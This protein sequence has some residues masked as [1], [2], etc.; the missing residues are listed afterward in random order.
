MTLGAVA[1]A[2]NPMVPKKVVPH[3][4]KYPLP[5]MPGMPQPDA[6][7]Q[8]N[9]V[10]P[11]V[12]SNGDDSHVSP[13][14]SR[15][16]TP[17]TSIV[18]RN[19]FGLNP[20]PIGQPIDPA[21]LNPPPKITLTGITTIFGPREALYKV[22]GVA[23]AGQP[24]QDQS[25]ILQEGQSEDEITVTS[26]DV[27]KGMVT[28]KN[29]NVTQT[30]LLSVGVASG[31]APASGGSLP[32]FAAPNP[33]FGRPPYNNNFPPAFNRQRSPQRPGF[34]NGMNQNGNN[35]NS[36]GQYNNNNYSAGTASVNMN[37]FG[38][39]SANNNNNNAST[40]NNASPQLSPDDSAALIAAQHAQW[41]QQGNPAAAIMPPTKYDND[42][43]QEVNNG[44]GTGN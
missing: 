29:H 10:P 30:L 38:G 23:R 25:Y 12:K 6:E 34:G 33:G 17:Y 22:A 4:P 39:S 5:A 40:A 15:Q 31:G 32:G 20:I 18:T 13:G 11:A 9:S 44:S 27:Q 35:I 41:E 3:H 2:D 26:I 1:Y 24:P 21:V 14:N 42:A 43:R 37:S 19:V 36:S 16:D 7:P 8:N 28:F